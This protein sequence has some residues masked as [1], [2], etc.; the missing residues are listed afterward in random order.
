MLGAMGP[1]RGGERRL[2]AE[3]E[4]ELP[5]LPAWDSDDDDPEDEADD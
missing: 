5:D 2:E 3:D 4:D 1:N